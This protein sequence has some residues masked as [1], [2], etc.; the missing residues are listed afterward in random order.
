MAE[1]QMAKIVVLYCSSSPFKKQEWEAI[2]SHFSLPDAEGVPTPLYQLFDLQFQGASLR[3]PL[4]C[5][6]RAVVRE[7]AISAYEAVR[8]PCIV[9]HAGLIFDHL[10]THNYPG[11]LTQ[12]MWDALAAE[13]FVRMKGV[14]G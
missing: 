10:S 12:P 1:G 9:E 7:K 6:L 8:V 13:G 2:K 5:D 14:A 3:E 11:G 4:L